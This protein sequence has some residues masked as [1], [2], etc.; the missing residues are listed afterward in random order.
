M[1]GGASWVVFGGVW[2]F[3]LYGCGCVM[4]ES[5]CLHDYWYV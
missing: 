4:L 1:L 2:C 3:V 5:D